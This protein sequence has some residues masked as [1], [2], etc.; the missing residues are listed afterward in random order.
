[1]ITHSGLIPVGLLVDRLGSKTIN[2]AGIALWSVELC[3]SSSA[4]WSW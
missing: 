1:V 4:N 2:A 3:A